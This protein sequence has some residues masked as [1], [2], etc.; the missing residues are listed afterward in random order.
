MPAKDCTNYSGRRFGRW[1]AIKFVTT[2]RWLCKCECG[3]ERV[4]SLLSL[5]SGKSKSCGCIWRE[6]MKSVHSTH[7]MYGHPS[8][9]TWKN[10]NARCG[11]KNHSDYHIYGG[12]G[13]VVCER[14]K[15]D[16][17]AFYEDFG[18]THPGPGWSIDRIDVNGN[19]EPGNVRWANAKQQ[20]MNQ[21]RTQVFNF[22]GREVN[23]RELGELLG[24]SHSTIS[25]RVRLF[26]KES[27]L[28]WAMWKSQ[29]A[30][31][32]SPMTARKV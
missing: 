10:I 9:R 6:V 20:A 1:T 5:K 16:F 3:V 4:V 13:I 24:V 17:A 30:G 21:R 26:G 32:R 29:N 19:Y 28:E 22:N 11:N 18:K 7:G 15:N 12:R 25:K 14:W 2:A 27:A 8:Y 23:S 31:K